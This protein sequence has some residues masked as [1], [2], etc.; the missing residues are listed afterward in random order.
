MENK[1]IVDNIRDFIRKKTENQKSIPYYRYNQNR[2]P[3]NYFKKFNINVELDNYKEIILQEET[4][5]ELGGTNKQSF[6]II[7]PTLELEFVKDGKITLI[8]QEINEIS[9]PSIDFGMFILIG[10]KKLSENDKNNLRQFNFISNGIEG[11]IIRTIPRRFWCRIS[12]N[13]IKKK[14]SFEF[15]GNAIIYLYK[16]KFENLIKSIE[17]LFINSYPNIINEFI[18]L[19]SEIR[20]QISAKWKK[21][22]EEWK[23][24]IDCEYDWACEIC[25]YKE[26]C[27]I[28]KE[29]LIER[30]RLD[31]R[32]GA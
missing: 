25:P 16:K 17:I 11:F 3:L 6:S 24:K 14:F 12:T 8:G 9:E 5:L 10:A 26:D 21:K 19:T 1:K 22:I 31:E 15:L 28:V 23:K 27:Y 13:V 32:E 4:R 20:E 18:K 7:Y 2:N 30:E 29:T